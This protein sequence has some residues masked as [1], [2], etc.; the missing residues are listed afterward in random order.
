M[1]QMVQRPEFG[2]MIYRSTIRKDRPLK[3]K[4][5]DYGMTPVKNERLKNPFPSGN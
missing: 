3:Q 4:L 1:D 5:D 2:G